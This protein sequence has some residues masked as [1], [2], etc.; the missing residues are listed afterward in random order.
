[1]RMGS[2]SFG[3]RPTEPTFKPDA[4]ACEVY[5]SSSRYAQ[6][7][8]EA[9]HSRATQNRG[10]IYVAGILG[11][12]VM[13]ASGGLA[14][15]TT[16]GAGTLGLLSISGGFAAASFATINNE[17]LALSYTIAANNV[18]QSLKQSSD[19]LTLDTA[20]G[21]Y[22]PASCANAISTLNA[23][24]TVARM[25]LETKRTSNAAMALDRAKHQRDLLDKQISA[26]QAGDPTR[27]TLSAVITKLET[28]PSTLKKDEPATVTLTVENVDLS[29][30]K[31]DDVKVQFGAKDRTVEAIARDTNDPNTYT[32]EFIAPAARPDANQPQYVPTLIIQGDRRVGS[33][34]GVEF[35]YP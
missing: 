18:D 20:T 3:M 35:V 26:V 33:K 34:K 32:V 13:A 28:V 30:V 16:V 4:T 11:L 6:E 25:D 31:L 24:V 15:A 1:M 2:A 29:R 12:G 19:R 14:L 22:T 9:Y 27:V 5:A 10:W 8:R 23:G 17:D 7:L 21:K